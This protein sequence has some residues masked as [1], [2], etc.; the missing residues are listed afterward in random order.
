MSDND[1][2][3]DYDQLLS[4]HFRLRHV[5]KDAF[6]KQYIPDAGWMNL[7]ADEII[8]NLRGV[9]VHI[10][11]PLLIQYPG[12]RINA[13][14]RKQNIDGQHSIGQAVDI[15]WPGFTVSNH[16]SIATW[17]I[18]NITFDEMIFSYGKTSAWIHVSY[19]LKGNKSFEDPSKVLSYNE[20]GWTAE[21]QVVPNPYAKGL[22]KILSRM[23]DRVIAGGTVFTG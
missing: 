4:P 16:Y 12:F 14:F 7:S 9:C 5:T 19:A 13:G 11:E 3:L 21:T 6:F 1:N 8:M 15:Q 10:L 18:E 22:V 17:M 2:C 23:N 20:G